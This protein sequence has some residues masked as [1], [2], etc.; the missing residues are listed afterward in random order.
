MVLISLRRLIIN[1]DD[2]EGAT[3]VALVNERRNIDSSIDSPVTR[4]LNLGIADLSLFPT[5]R[6]YY[7]ME[8]F[9][10]KTCA[11]TR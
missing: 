4:A 1:A 5:L 11:I 10:T 2:E 6:P 7:T 3:E 8:D 9:Q